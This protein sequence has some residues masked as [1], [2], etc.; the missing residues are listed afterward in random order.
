MNN[1]RLFFFSADPPVKKAL[2]WN[3]CDGL[4]HQYQLKLYI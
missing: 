1:F 2:F 3:V 4:F